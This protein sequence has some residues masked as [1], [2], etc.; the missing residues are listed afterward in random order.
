MSKKRVERR[1]M[2]SGQKA[3]LLLLLWFLLGDMHR[4]S[5]LLTI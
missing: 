5:F 1:G 4:P 3:P 2:T